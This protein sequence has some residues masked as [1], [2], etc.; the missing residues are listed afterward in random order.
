MV[1]SQYKKGYPKYIDSCYNEQ[2]R[3]NFI[4]GKNMKKTL[5][6]GLAAAVI[7]TCGVNSAGAVNW[8]QFGQDSTGVSWFIDQDSIKADDKN[9]TVDIKAQDSEGYHFIATEEFNRK[10][11]TVKDVKVT[12]YNPQGYVEREEPVDNTARAV[13]VGSP[14][15]AV[16]NHFWAPTDNVTVDNKKDDNKKVDKKADKKSD[17]KAEKKDNKKK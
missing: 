12:L 7:C 15:E 2:I 4:R 11:K 5:L 16:Y 1:M 8:Q 13:T 3:F 9:A 6:A 14:S 17:K 10:D